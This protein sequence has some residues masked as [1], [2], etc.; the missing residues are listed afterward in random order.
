MNAMPIFVAKWTPAT[1]AALRTEF[2]LMPPRA[3]IEEDESALKMW[4]L[5]RE[6]SFMA[7]GKRV[8]ALPG[9]CF[10]FASVPQLFECA[11]DDTDYRVAEASLRHDC[12]FI[13][14]ALG[15]AESNAVFFSTMLDNGMP[16]VR[17]RLYHRAVSG[18][19]G[20]S[21]Y[22]RTTTLDRYRAEKCVRVE[23]GNE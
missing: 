23:G 7:G 20:H 22:N 11:F 21:K 8:T 9:F 17:A 5:T 12:L 6:Y 13:T 3:L 15:F 2:A 4:V 16:R 19:V 14:K 1:D 10:D 18:L